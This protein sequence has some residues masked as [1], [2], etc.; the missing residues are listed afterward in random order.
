MPS[1]K[2]S[3]CNLNGIEKS[4]IAN[5]RHKLITYFSFLKA[6]CVLLSH[7][8]APFF[9]KSVRGAAMF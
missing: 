5:M 6:C 1:P 3:H 2:A 9:V 4:R 8:K 7:A